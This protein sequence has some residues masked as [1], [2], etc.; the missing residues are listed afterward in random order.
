MMEIRLF[1]MVILWQSERRNKMQYYVRI[2]NPIQC[3]ENLLPKTYR[4]KERCVREVGFTNNKNDAMQRAEQEFQKH[5]ACIVFLMK[6]V[7][8]YPES[9]KMWKGKN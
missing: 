5:P 7:N 2:F 1:D 6:D 9:I 8:G 4:R 3:A